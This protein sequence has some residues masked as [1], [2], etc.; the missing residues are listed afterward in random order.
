MDLDPVDASKY[1][2]LPAEPYL[3]ITIPSLQD[4]SLAP[5][6][7]HVMSIVAQFTPYKLAGAASLVYLGVRMLLDRSRELTIATFEQEPSPTI[8]R[9]GMVTNVTSR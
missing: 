1:G 5:P 7:R 8:F 2:E 3:D 9:A 4:P 6:G